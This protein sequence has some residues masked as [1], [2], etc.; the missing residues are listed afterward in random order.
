[1]SNKTKSE[2]KGTYGSAIGVV[3]LSYKKAGYP[4]VKKIADSWAQDPDFFQVIVRKVSQDD[5]GIQFIYLSS[6]IEGIKFNSDFMSKF[7]DPIK[8]SIYAY[9]IAY[10]TGKTKEEAVEGMIKNIPIKE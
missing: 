2:K 3:K 8:D 5:F 9:D 6:E 10:G 7:I 4:D 1:M